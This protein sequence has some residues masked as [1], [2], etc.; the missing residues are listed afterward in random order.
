MKIFIF[1]I[2]EDEQLFDDRVPQDSSD[3][4][5]TL[6]SSDESVTQE[7]SDESVTQE[8]SDESSDE[9]DEVH[10]DI[11]PDS[12]DEDL[13]IGSRPSRMKTVNNFLYY[14]VYAI[15]YIQVVHHISDNG[16]EY[17]LKFLFYIFQIFGVHVN[18]Q[19]LSEFCIAFPPSLYMARKLLKIDRDDFKRYAVCPSCHVLYDIFD[20]VTEV[21]GVREGKLCQNLI[22]VRGKETKCSSPLV[23]KVICKGNVSKFYP[24]KVYCLNSVISGIEAVLKRQEV[25]DVWQHWKDWEDSSDVLRDVYDGKVW[26]KFLSFNGIPFL[27]K[28]NGIGLMLNVDWFQP[29]KN[30]NDYSVGVIYF[31]ILNL[32]RSIRF[33]SENVIIAGLIPAFKKEPHSINTFLEPIVKELNQLWKGIELQSSLSQN[34]ITFRAAL[35]CVSCDIPA[36][37]K[38]CGFK[39]HA[40]RLG[41][42]KCFK[43]FQGGFGEKRDYSGFDRQNWKPRTKSLHNLYS[44]KV[45]NARTK[46]EAEKLATQYGTYYSVLIELEYFDA[47]QFC[48]IDPMHNLFLGTAKNMYKLWVE[49]GILSSSNI[50]KI[51]ERLAHVNANTDIGRIPTHISGNYGVFSAAEWKNWTTIFSLYCLCGILPEK[52]YRCWEKFVIACRILCKPF[53]SQMD[54]QKADMLLLDFCKTFEKVYTLKDVTCNMHLHNHLK[55]CLLDFGPVHV[56]WCFSFERFN[57]AFGNFYTNNKSVEIQFMRRIVTSKFCDSFQDTL[58]EGNEQ[59]LSKLFF[60]HENT[61]Q[62]QL[63][64]VVQLLKVSEMDIVNFSNLDSTFFISLPKAFKMEAL[65]QEDIVFLMASYRKMYP[66]SVLNIGDMSEIIKKFGHVTIL[67]ETFGSKLNHRKSRS[68]DVLVSW[69]VDGSDAGHPLVD[70]RPCRVDFFFNHTMVIQEISIT[71]VFAKVSL[72]KEYQER[73]KYGKALQIWFCNKFETGSAESFIPVQR[74][75]SRFSKGITGVSKDLMCVCP[76]PRRILS[77]NDQ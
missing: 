42:H 15:L 8:S 13:G 67:G 38:C 71:N 59:G 50:E 21:R 32:P 44:R 33:R 76:I 31:V 26:Q 74:I 35:L 9:D 4:S 54:I 2:Q 24:I 69:K 63:T 39:S 58:K 14:I 57:G 43:E 23:K 56:F 62:Y 22:K 53:L 36:A 29:F 34:S 73:F 18:N 37:R 27:S 47:I 68:S 51:E 16:I 60:G 45:K 49:K 20:C 40:G 3:E 55:E 48:V 19:L 52:D 46:T 28:E 7:S 25:K 17:I 72:Y 1:N 11:D 5:V 65:D 66:S 41:C 6:D 30:R 12:L 64:D 70:L 77:D 75:H 10:W 61:R